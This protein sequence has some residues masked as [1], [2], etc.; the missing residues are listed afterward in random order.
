MATGIYGATPVVFGRT[1]MSE[2]QL[3][4]ATVN[5]ATNGAVVAGETAQAEPET[6]AE[7]ATSA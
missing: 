5:E 1:V 4:E 2:Q 6:A 3:N 7:A